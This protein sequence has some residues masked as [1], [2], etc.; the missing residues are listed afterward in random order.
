MLTT[1]ELDRIHIHVATFKSFDV[2]SHKFNTKHYQK[3]YRALT[4]VKKIISKFEKK[5]NKYASFYFMISLMF[6]VRKPGLLP[7]DDKCVIL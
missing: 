5:K 3:Y 1:I 4:D 2:I 6:D 7:E